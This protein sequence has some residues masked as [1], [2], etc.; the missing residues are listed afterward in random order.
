MRR[1][2]LSL[3][4]IISFSVSAFD[5]R[6]E[7]K[8]QEHFKLVGGAGLH[9]FDSQLELELGLGFDAEF[10]YIGFSV[11]VPFKVAVY[12]FDN[13]EPLLNFKINDWNSLR[14]YFKIIHYFHYGSKQEN[15]H[16]YLGKIN[17]Y[18]LANGAI[19]RNYFNSNFYNYYKLGSYYSVK[20]D[21]LGLDGMIDDLLFPN[22]IDLF[23]H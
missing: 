18:S 13:K 9:F 4:L 19:V 3:L 17:D 2:L 23:F 22:I 8:F 1:I 7:K 12:S 15:L 20:N 6:K 16:F 21:Y 14:D 11:Y 5:Y 10:E